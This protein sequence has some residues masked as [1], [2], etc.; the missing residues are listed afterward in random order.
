MAE[1][2]TRNKRVI[3]T[4]KSP[5]NEYDIKREVKVYKLRQFEIVEVE[6]ERIDIIRNAV[7]NAKTNI[8]KGAISSDVVLGLSTTF[9]GG[10]IGCVPDI[11][12][13]ITSKEITMLIFFH[14]GLLLI[15]I[16]LFFVY[17]SMY[18]KKS[19]DTAALIE[20]IA[21]ETDSI[22]NNLVIPGNDIPE[23][24]P[25]NNLSGTSKQTDGRF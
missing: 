15:A 18:R 3:S 11:V 12:E 19:V 21:E 4:A 20:R 9:F 23:N 13:M 14:F 16:V 1:T 25:P 24:I 5:G 2:K 8:N 10:F 7:Q 17:L 22:S 6:K